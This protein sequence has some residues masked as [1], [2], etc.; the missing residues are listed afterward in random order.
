[1]SRFCQ[2]FA[3]SDFTPAPTEIHAGRAADAGPS[4]WAPLQIEAD[5]CFQR[6][7]N[8]AQ[9]QGEVAGAVSSDESVSA[10][11]PAR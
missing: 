9:R 11:V 1:M 4:R 3:A 6:A 10:L 7:L 2:E 5:A 8:F